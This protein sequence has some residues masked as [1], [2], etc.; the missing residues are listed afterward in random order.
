MKILAGTVVLMASWVI[1]LVL[2]NG[3]WC[4][5]AIGATLYAMLTSE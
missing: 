4:L 5:G 1:S 3:A 2:P